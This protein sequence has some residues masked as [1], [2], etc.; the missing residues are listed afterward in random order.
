[1][2]SRLPLSETQM[3]LAARYGDA[4]I[5]L[6]VIYDEERDEAVEL[7]PFRNIPGQI[8]AGTL[9]SAS[10]RFVLETAVPDGTADGEAISA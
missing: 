7:R 9:R 8:G 6:L 5:L 1:M 3:R 4:Y 10:G 2:R